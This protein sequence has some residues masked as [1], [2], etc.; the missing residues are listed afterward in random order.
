MSWSERSGRVYYR[1]SEWADGKAV[2]VYVGSG[3]AALEARES[4]RAERERRVSQAWAWQAE[5]SACFTATLKAAAAVDACSLFA[6]AVLVASGFHR[7]D[8][9]PWRRRRG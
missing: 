6:R 1:R 5:E 9:G 7:H 3:G 2:K 8:R 4:D